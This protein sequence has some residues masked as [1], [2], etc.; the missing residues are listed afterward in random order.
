MFN[1]LENSFSNNGVVFFEETQQK[2]LGDKRCICTKA[3]AAV[4]ERHPCHQ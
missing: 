4:S 1:I 2:K 3:R